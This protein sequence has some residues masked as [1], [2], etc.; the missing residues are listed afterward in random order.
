MRGEARQ[1]L[2][3]VLDQGKGG[4]YQFRDERD[5]IVRTSL[6]RLD[7]LDIGEQALCFGRIDRFAKGDDDARVADSESFHIG[8]LGVSGEDLE[9]LVVDWRA[10]VAEPFYRATGRDPHGPGPASPP[11]RP[12]RA[13]LGVEDERFVDPSQGPRGTHLCRCPTPVRRTG[14]AGER[15]SRRGRWSS[16]APVPSSRRSRGPGPGTCATSSPPSSG[17]RTRSSAPRS[18]RHGGPGRPRHR[19]DGG[20]AAPGGIPSL[21]A[22]LP[23]GAPGGAGDRAQPPVPAL[24]RARAA[25]AGGERRHPVHHRRAG[26]RGPRSAGSTMP[27][28]AEGRGPHGRRGR[29]GRA[30]P[31]ASAAPRRRGALRRHRAAPAGRRVPGSSAGP[32]AAP[33]PTT[34]VA[35]SWSSSWCAGWPTTTA[36]A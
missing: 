31:P 24:H 13:V 26:P 23:A 20:G 4:T 27:A 21:Y 33:A 7:Q 34:P 1:E 18:R 11:G 12:G 14:S 5:V 8:R 16:G 19:Q 3:G 15:R 30:H 35:G 9:P 32:A 29:P 10:P 28:A 36:N 17:S 6:A 25:V 22:P 2:Q